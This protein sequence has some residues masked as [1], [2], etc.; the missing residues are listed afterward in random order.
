MTHHELIYLY[1][2]LAERLGKRAAK[3]YLK[4]P[5]ELVAEA[6]YVLCCSIIEEDLST[7]ENLESWLRPVICR[8][9]WRYSHN[10]ACSLRTAGRLTEQGK[11]T[12]R[13]IAVKMYADPNTVEGSDIEIGVKEGKYKDK[14]PP[15]A[16]TELSEQQIKEIMESLFTTGL[17]KTIFE[18]WMRNWTD[19]QIAKEMGRN[20]RLISDVRARIIHKIENY[21]REANQ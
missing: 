16:P 2:P 8:Q 13:V 7:I 11:R 17:E 19:Q 5:D 20:K 15:R 18:F 10:F 3:R 12:P 14:L 6:Y 4:D 1:M 9:L 21:V